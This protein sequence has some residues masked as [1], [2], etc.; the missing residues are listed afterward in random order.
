[1]MGEIL[2]ECIRSVGVKMR[3]QI[4]AQIV[5]SS[6]SI[7]PQKITEEGESG[8]DTCAGWWHRESRVPVNLLWEISFNVNELEFSPF[9][10]KTNKIVLFEVETLKN[11]K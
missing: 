4:S 10:M 8:L 2:S 7:H 11:T 1:M 6:Q 5:L 3:C 9:D